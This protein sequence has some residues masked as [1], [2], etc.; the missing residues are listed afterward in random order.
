MWSVG[1]ERWDLYLGESQSGLAKVGAAPHWQP[2]VDP[3]SELEARLHAIASSS[4]KRWTRPTVAVWLSGSLARPFLL[5]PVA[6][7]RGRR[8][9]LA[10]AQAAAAEATGIGG[11]VAVWF[12][13]VPTTHATVAVAMPASLRTVALELCKAHRVQLG[14]LRPWWA[15]ALEFAND[16]SPPQA[17]FAAEDT[18][19]LVLLGWDRSNWTSADACVPG[20]LP[21]QEASL[22]ARRAFVAGVATPLRRRLSPG[23]GAADHNWLLQGAV[24]T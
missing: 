7:L 12:D 22:I 8:E 6:G 2:H 19:S 4:R 24:S 3:T 18:D 13:Q 23:A 20:P 11:E 1:T 16:N 15:L 14:S 10:L 9:A 5:A 17:L 21:V